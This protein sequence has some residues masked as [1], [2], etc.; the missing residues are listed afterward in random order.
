MN[1]LVLPALGNAGA[2]IVAPDCPFQNWKSDISENAVLNLIE[3]LQNSYAIDK[4]R[5]AVTGFSMGGRGAWHMAARHPRIFSAAVRVAGMPDS[6]DL[7]KI[8]SVP[9]YLIHSDADQILPLEPTREA[10]RM[11]K[12]RKIPVQLKI[13]KGI[14]HY[15]T[16]GFI[17][18]LQKSK[19][20]LKKVWQK[21][22]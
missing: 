2:I 13:V 21:P 4:K 3:H 22:V 6:L 20:W 10:Y 15:Q 7:E 14:S 11:L 12:K 9:L 5:I 19:S 16:A 1:I 17:P 8:E 18:A